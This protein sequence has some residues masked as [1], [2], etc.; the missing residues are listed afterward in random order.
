MPPER[1][2]ILAPFVPLAKAR[3]SAADAV[4]PHVGDGAEASQARQRVDVEAQPAVP[5][6]L[7]HQGAGA[8]HHPELAALEAVQGTFLTELAERGR[9][10][11]VAGHLEDPRQRVAGAAVVERQR[12]RP[13]RVVDDVGAGR[14]HQRRELG[15]PGGEVDA[16]DAAGRHLLGGLDEQP[17]PPAVLRGRHPSAEPGQPDRVEQA[18]VVEDDVR[19]DV[20]GHA[21]KRGVRGH[22]LQPEPFVVVPEVD[23]A[24]LEQAV[25]RLHPAL[26]LQPGQR[27]RVGEEHVGRGAGVELRVEGGLR[28]ARVR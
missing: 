14:A 21:L 10:V 7:G 19:R 16:L 23:P 2:V 27:G 20:V 5:A 12:G 22:R 18:P 3:K 9:Q 6:Q 8:D 13:L 24:L 11:R 4:A 15:Q 17:P 25:D 1:A 26:A 28:P